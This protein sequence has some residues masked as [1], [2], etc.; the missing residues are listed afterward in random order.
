[1]VM[2]LSQPSL[3]ES[4]DNKTDKNNTAIHEFVHLIDKT[5]GTVDGS[6]EFLLDKGYIKPWLQLIHKNI[7]SIENNDSDINPYAATNEA[8]FFAVAAEYFFERPLL[9]EEKHPKL[10][11]LLEI[12]FKQ[13]PKTDSKKQKT[14]APVS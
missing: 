13:D 7:A 4:F 8:E 12:I 6:P 2:I 10:Y 1:H 9:L 3:H 5:D 14:R 11:A